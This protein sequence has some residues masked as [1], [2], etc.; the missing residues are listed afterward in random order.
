MHVVHYGE[1]EKA[2]EIPPKRIVN[3]L[4]VANEDKF[5]RLR[6]LVD[7]G[8]EKGFVLYDE[9]NE[10][11]PD[12]MAA[13]R[14]IDDLL[15]DFA[16]AGVEILEE[17][18][19]EFEKKLDDGEELGDLELVQD[20]IDKTNDPVRMYLREMGTVP[21]LTR[22]GEIEL[23][24]RIERG[25]RSVS[26]AL[27]RSALVVKEVIQMGDEI[28][29]G[30]LMARDV[31][32]V[33]DPLMTDEALDAQTGDLLNAICEIDKLY[34]KSQQFRQKLQAISRHMKPKQHRNL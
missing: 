12:E 25:Q 29:T 19:L 24:K 15:A 32:M 20:F 1:P 2:R 33:S 9:V 30:T 34:K 23:A 18:K 21:L 3:R 11:L 17:P 5:G 14:E 28:K 13:G 22:E 6:Q 27:S 7:S 31:L 4:E 8:K 26:K 16:T 10:I